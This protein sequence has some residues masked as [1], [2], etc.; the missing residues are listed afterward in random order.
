ML[1]EVDK[2][3][4]RVLIAKANIPYARFYNRFRERFPDLKQ[5]EHEIKSTFNL[6]YVNDEVLEMLELWANEFNEKFKR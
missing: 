5:T 6:R 4:S 1:T 3:K 2:R